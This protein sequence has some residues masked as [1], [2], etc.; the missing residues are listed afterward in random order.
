MSST[1][2]RL[3]AMSYTSWATAAGM[4]TQPSSSPTMGVAPSERHGAPAVD[5]GVAGPGLVR[6]G[7]LAGG[8][9]DGEDGEA[10][11]AEHA[12]V[13]DGA[14]GH[15]AANLGGEGGAGSGT[16][17]KSDRSRSAR[18]FRELRRG[19]LCG[20]GRRADGARGGSIRAGSGRLRG[21]EELRTPFW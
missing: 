9:G 21:R 8:G 1:T 4:T 14:V 5:D 3:C 16:I 17:L 12:G 19:P 15:E 11:I 6:V 20:G 10:V 7:A 13:T 18:A 2:S